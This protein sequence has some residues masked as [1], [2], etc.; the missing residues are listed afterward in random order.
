MVK[1][2]NISFFLII[3]KKERRFFIKKTFVK[4]FLG[5]LA[6]LCFAFGSASCNVIG[7]IVGETMD[8]VLPTRLV[9]SVGDE[10]YTLKK[11]KHA[12][13]EVV[14][15]E[16]H[17]GLPVTSIESGAFWNCSD[18][19]SVVIPDSVTSIGSSAFRDCN[20]LTSVYY[21]GAVEDWSGI[22]IDNSN[23]YNDKLIN[24]T[25]YYYSETEPATTGNYWHYDENGEVAVW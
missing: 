18:L 25:R 13:G 7:K 14:T 8:Q 23:G 2:Y 3:S 17:K 11:V 5:L 22:T 6:G 10:G 20:S 24:A 1:R 19:T 4:F 21:K 9:Y 12:K 15:P 16:M